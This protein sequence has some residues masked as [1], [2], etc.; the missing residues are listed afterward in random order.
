MDQRYKVLVFGATGSIGGAVVQQLRSRGHHVLCVARSSASQ[1]VLQAAGFDT[2][3]G[4]IRTPQALSNVIQ[5]VDAVIPLAATWTEDMDQVDQNLT[6]VVLKELI[7]AGGQK[8]FIYT[9]G[10]WAYGNTGDSVATESTPHDPLLSFARLSRTASLVQ[11][12]SRIKGMVILPAMVYERDGGVFEPML[13]A[14]KSD[15]RI[16]VAGNLDT[17]WPLVHKDDLAVLYALMLE[18]GTGG[19]V[20]NGATFE[21]VAV[22]TLAA[23][24][25]RRFG[26][27]RAPEVLSLSRALELFGSYA[28]G[29]CLDQQMSGSKAMHELNWKPEHTSLEKDLL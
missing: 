11:Q 28:E 19:A 7:T 8:T 5:S 12:E 2:V 10:C 16:R 17:R 25:S 1:H 13:E 6:R 26:L 14:V 29:Y 18:R 21:G 24:L 20:Y 23:L 27:T 4:D 22:G 9:S 3:R 15:Q